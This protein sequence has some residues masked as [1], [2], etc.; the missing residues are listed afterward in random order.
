MRRLG[1]PRLERH[2]TG[3]HGDRMELSYPPPRTPSGKVYQYSPNPDAAPRLFLIGEAPEGRS[4]KDEHRRRIRRQPGPGE[5][6]CPYSG[7]MAEDQAFV[8]LDDI[9]AIKKQIVHEASADLD[10]YLGQFARDFNR[11]Q[12]PGGFI[13]MKMDFKPARRP[14]PL[15]IREDLLRDL[16]CDV[17]QRPYAVY[18]IALFCP[19]CGSPNLALHFQREVAIVRDQIAIADAQADAGKPEIAYRLMGNAHEDVLTAFETALKTVY[20]HLVRQHLPER[21]AELCAPKAVGNAFQNVE[22]GREKFGVF[23]IDPFAGMGADDL[24]VL[25]LNIQKR[26]VIGHNLGIADEHYVELTQDEQPGETVRLMGDEINRFA[27]ICLAVVSGLE[28]WLLQAAAV[29]KPK[30]GGGDAQG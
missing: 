14:T 27:D 17:C 23:G 7:L 9:E 10:D 29:P 15:V 25:T 21:A 16:Q 18:A 24:G 12:R 11:N 13:S 28:A 22:R 5:T 1:F 20:K 3:G 8:H 30:E 4:V 26:H 6:V 19:D 2:R